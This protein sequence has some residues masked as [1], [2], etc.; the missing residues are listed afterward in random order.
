MMT[1]F[2]S[3]HAEDHNA[4]SHTS[5]KKGNNNNMTRLP[6]SVVN[7]MRALFSL[8]LLALVSLYLSM[9]N[10]AG[11]SLN[12]T[13]QVNGMFISD[14][15]INNNNILST[16]LNS[17]INTNNANKVDA[18]S[19]T[20]SQSNNQYRKESIDNNNNKYQYYYDDIG[21]LVS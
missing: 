6:S 18:S 3:S 17:K 9:A 13:K 5:S 11:Q 10:K 2:S 7:N 19:S 8:G 21:P 1:I 14:N 20:S 15:I 16:D 4:S 12:I